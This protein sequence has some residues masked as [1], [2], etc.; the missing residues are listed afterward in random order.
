MAWIRGWFCRGF[1]PCIGNALAF[2]QIGSPRSSRW[3]RIDDGP[4]FLMAIAQ[5]VLPWII[6]RLVLFVSEGNQDLGFGALLAA[7]LC[8]FSLFDAL[9][10]QHYIYHSITTVQKVING[11]NFRIYEKAL[12]LTRKARAK[13]PTGDVVNYIGADTRAIA[14]FPWTIVELFYAL[15]MIL[16]V[17]SM[18]FVYLGHAAWASLAV[19][20][21]MSP[22]TKVIGTR[23]TQPRLL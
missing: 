16:G 15:V 17:S 6:H 3:D 5:L 23:F 2:S 21:A 22:L 1:Y 18:L 8:L 9:L 7:S 12:K 14:E 13:Y 20:C 11:V 4:L 10:G 19:L